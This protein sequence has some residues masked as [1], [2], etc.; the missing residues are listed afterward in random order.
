MNINFNTKI[1]SKTVRKFNSEKLSIEKESKFSHVGRIKNG[2]KIRYFYGNFIDLNSRAA[3]EMVKD[4]AY[5]YYWLKKSG[6]PIPEG[7]EFFF[8]AWAKKMK[9][10]NDEKKALSYAHKKGWPL[11]VKPNDLKGG[12]GVFLVSNEKS[13]K[14]SLQ[15]IKK[16]GVNVF[17]IQKY[18][19]GIEFRLMVLDKKII[20]KYYKTPLSIEGDG[21]NNIRDLLIKNKINLKDREIFEILKTNKIKNNYIPPKGEKIKLEVTANLSTNGQITNMEDDEL[22]SKWKKIVSQISDIFNLRYFAL[23]IISLEPLK[24]EPKKFVILEIN[25]SPSLK[26]YYLTSKNNKKRVEEIYKK[27]VLALFKK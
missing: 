27:I 17:L 23:D 5:T 12:E 18:I 9:S 11:I 24:K 21:K 25:S 2:K 13:L 16:M 3:S 26:H 14:K 6:L 7:R 20:L 22:N 1:I 8:N 10:S 19:L 4:K 15:I